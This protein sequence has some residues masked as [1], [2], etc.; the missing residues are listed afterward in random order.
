MPWQQRKP[1]HWNLELGLARP[2]PILKMVVSIGDCF[3][4]SL[5]MQLSCNADG[6]AWPLNF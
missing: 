6:N 1:L 4:L 3:E 2:L 5:P